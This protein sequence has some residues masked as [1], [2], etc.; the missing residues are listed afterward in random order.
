[1]DRVRVVSRGDWVL[2]TLATL[3]IAI[4]LFVAPAPTQAASNGSWSVYPTTHPGQKPRVVFN[5]SLVPGKTLGDSVT[6]DNTSS[7]T[8]TFLLYSA[9]AFNTPGGGLSLTRRLDPV[10]GIGAWIH[11]A[12]SSITVPA[13]ARVNVGFL[14]VV[15]AIAT[16]GDHLGGIVAEQTN[17]TPSSAG[18]VPINVIQAVGVRFYGRVEGPVT[19]NLAIRSADLTV[20]QSATSLFGGSTD[21]TVSFGV[22]NSGNAVLTPVAHLRISGALGTATTETYQLGPLLPGQHITAR[23]RVT[24]HAFGPLHLV[25][26]VTVP[27]LTARAFATNWNLPWALF[28]IFIVLLV[29]LGTLFVWR[30]RRAPGP[31]ARASSDKQEPALANN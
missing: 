7:I 8:Q 11:L 16:P 14:L 4:G 19:R 29:L 12:H 13:H 23:H 18:N 2:A 9:D 20:D 1:M 15:P 5:L 25:V 28:A 17:G 22:T 24:V 6:V 27:R 30:R 3:T 26:T 10:Q 21:A 31:Q